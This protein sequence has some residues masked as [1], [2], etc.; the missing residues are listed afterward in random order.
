MLVN[1]SL[2]RLN[3]F[4]IDNTKMEKLDCLKQGWARAGRG[5]GEAV[6]RGKECK[7]LR[8]QGRKTLVFGGYESEQKNEIYYLVC[9]S[10]LCQSIA[11]LDPHNIIQAFFKGRLLLGL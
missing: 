4:D 7:G 8:G 5:T 9:K 1:S 6:R 3:G 11:V 2:A 10:H